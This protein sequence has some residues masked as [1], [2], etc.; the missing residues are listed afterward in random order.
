MKIFSLKIVKFAAFLLFFY[1]LFNFFCNP[2]LASDNIF[3]LHLTQPQ[4]IF[5][6]KN[7]INS[8]NGDWGWA[9]IVIRTDQLDFQTWQE[10]FDNCRKFH[11]IPIVRLST[12]AEGGSW[13]QPSFSDIDN[14]ANF[15]NSLNWPTKT[16]HIILFN[17][18]NHASEWG[19]EINVKSYTD[20]AIYSNQ[21]FKS[22]NTDYFILS[23]ALDLASPSDLPNFQSAENIFK[24]IYAY[25]PEF[26]NNIDGIASHSYPNHGYVGTPNDT[27]QHS[28]QGYKW[29][30][31][32]LKSLGVSKD[33]PVFITETG[34]PH[35]EGEDN[36]NHYYTTKTTAEFLK[37]ALAMWSQDKNVKAVTPFIYNYPNAPF[38]HFSWLDKT[39][40]IYPEYQQ[41]IDMPK[42]KNS[43]E[44]ITK[45]ELVKI[46]LPFLILSNT[47][48]TGQITLKNTG[49][50]IWGESPF[51]LTPQTTTNVVLDS[52]CVNAN[53]KIFPNQTK[54]FNF[55][56]RIVKTDEV[57]NKTFISWTDL[58]PFEITP[59][60]KNAT[61][62]HPRVTFWLKFK[63]IFEQI[64]K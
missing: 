3:G 62:Y 57:L 31:D 7:I 21:K 41:I 9:T 23:A 13:K 59:F 14:L 34:W 4:D 15:L 20:T 29:E 19:G 50:S 24:E 12:I 55:K 44:Q 18:I 51:C 52:I 40:K 5:H 39:E 38:D 26:F 64:F 42:S 36:K 28:I 43:P 58:P 49:Q 33:F 16:R 60:D 22:L 6:A 61:I 27:G 47:E 35:K 46:Y 56:F 25:K 37:I 10:F 8:Q 11:I 45:Y 54:T 2:I 48:Y 32:Y 63:D 17:E 53:E 1:A 30:L